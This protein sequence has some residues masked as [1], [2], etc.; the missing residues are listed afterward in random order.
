MNDDDVSTARD[1]TAHVST[2]FESPGFEYTVRAAFDDPA[3]AESWV[4]WLRDGHVAEVLAA[5]AL[6]A[7]IVRLDDDGDGVRY[8]VRYTFP[9]AVAFAAYERDHAP[10][11]RAEGA[12]R[13]PPSVAHYSR[14]NGRVIWSSPA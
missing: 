14:S 10:R 5:G 13:F 4:A 12:G 9:S 1:S 11:L 3:L 8:A 2:G 7:V 6:R